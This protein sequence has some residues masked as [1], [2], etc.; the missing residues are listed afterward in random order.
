[1]SDYSPTLT[2]PSQSDDIWRGAR[3]NGRVLVALIFRE[4]ALR[5]GTSPFSYVW[6]LVEPAILVG[7][8]LFA[9]VY[10]RN[11]SAAFG[12]SSV[13]FLLT[14]VVVFRATRN[15]INKASRAIST[16]RALFDFGVVKPPDTVIAKA[17]VEFII[18]ILILTFFFS[19]MQRIL[20]QQIITNFQGFVIALL[21]I[22]YFCLAVSMFNATIGAL[23]PMW[24]S[25]WKILSVPLLMTSGVLFVPATMPPEILAIIIWN[26]FLHCVE[27]LRS[28]SYLDYISVGEPLYLL[29]FSTVTLL[30]ALSVERLFRKEIIRSRGDDDDEEEI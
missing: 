2:Q 27:E 7:I 16:N 24:R 11:V 14:G 6:T 29:S 18:W 20:G 26:P 25:I 22:L 9:R 23:F 8:L 4:A 13:V 17:I 19:A 10:V 28:N 1:M 3:T 5:F 12:E 30:L 15:I 21:Q